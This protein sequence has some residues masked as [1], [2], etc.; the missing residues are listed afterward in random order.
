MYVWAKKWW[1]H[2]EKLRWQWKAKHLKMY[3]LLKMRISHCHLS[4]REGVQKFRLLDLMKHVKPSKTYVTTGPPSP[5][6]LPNHGIP[7][8]H[9]PVAARLWPKSE[10]SLKF[11][12]RDGEESFHGTDGGVKREVVNL[13]ADEAILEVEQMEK[14][15]LGA[16]QLRLGKLNKIGLRCH[17]WKRM[18]W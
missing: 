3:L 17:G 9:N 4:F 15:Y 5:R 8:L 11:I 13:D 1:I 18:G 7:G 2:P 10:D 12:L 16:I 6:A 14:S